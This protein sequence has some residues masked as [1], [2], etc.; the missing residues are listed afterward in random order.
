MDPI[1]LNNF[2]EECVAVL[3]KITSEPPRLGA[4]HL[5]RPN[6]NQ[7]ELSGH[8]DGTI[9]GTLLFTADGPTL[10]LLLQALAPGQS[11]SDELR[12]DAIA[13]VINVLVGRAHELFPGS[14][15]SV[16]EIARGAANKLPEKMRF[17]VIVVP[18]E[19]QQHK[20]ALYIGLD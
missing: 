10:D 5:L 6:D 11:T 12:E 4:S 2:I 7:Q 19:W 13:E 20:S 3:R 1:E 15:I 18:L 14:E 17:P 16:P 8:V 9:N